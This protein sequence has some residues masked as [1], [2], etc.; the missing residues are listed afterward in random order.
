MKAER[1]ICSLIPWL[2]QVR[3]RRSSQELA[4]NSYCLSVLKVTRAILN[5]QRLQ[6]RFVQ[7][8]LGHQRQHTSL[9]LP[10]VNRCL[11]AAQLHAG[12]MSSLKPLQTSQILLGLPGDLHPK[13]WSEE[14][15]Q[16]WV[17]HVP[18]NAGTLY[19]DIL[20]IP[21]PGTVASRATLPL[22]Y[23]S[24]SRQWYQPESWVRPLGTPALKLLYCREGRLLR[25]QNDEERTVEIIFPPARLLWMNLYQKLRQN[26][27][28]A[29]FIYSRFAAYSVIFSL[30]LLRR[31]SFLFSFA[32]CDCLFV[33]L[34]F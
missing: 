20:L 26:W 19:A 10:Y 33:F 21:V 31:P 17:V 34:L 18:S 15:L 22:G 14:L 5:S 8:E 4:E 16:R 30:S 28:S 24:F 3:F 9:L 29:V 12:R 7:C 25:E 27:D 6:P 13:A 1:S 32:V 2:R 23:G 11:Q